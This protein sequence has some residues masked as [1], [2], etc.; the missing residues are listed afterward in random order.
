[1]N[2]LNNVINLMD[3]HTES[4]LNVP[5]EDY[6]EHYSLVENAQIEIVDVPDF[7][8]TF[9]VPSE[10]ANIISNTHSLK[11]CDNVRVYDS[12]MRENFNDTYIENCDLI[13]NFSDNFGD[14]KLVPYSSS[15]ENDSDTSLPEKSKFRKRRTQVNK[16]TW[17]AEKNK[18]LREKGSQYY[19]K[20]KKNSKWVYESLRE[21]KRLKDRCKCTRKTGIIKCGIIKDEERMKLFNQFWK[22]Y[23]WGEKKIFVNDTVQ[24]AAT[25]R[26]RNRKL[27]DSSRR[28]QSFKYN[29]KTADGSYVRVCKTMYLNTLGIGRMTVIAWKDRIKDNT[30]IPSQLRV[31]RDS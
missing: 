31:N 16:N 22:T 28:A 6:I 27:S 20:I 3:N 15:S 26:H 8:T 21:P 14:P 23:T 10:N 13:S 7:F 9:D 19:G 11:I 18:K 17:F 12:S 1:M 25:K 5:L 2:T 30:C 24:S 4:S 29:L